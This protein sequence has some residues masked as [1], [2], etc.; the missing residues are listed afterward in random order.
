MIDLIVIRFS[1]NQIKCN[2]LIY[3]NT[4]INKSLMYVSIFIVKTLRPHLAR[5]ISHWNGI[6][7]PLE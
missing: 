4:Q 5:E 7:I 3:P 6:T 1:D 2:L